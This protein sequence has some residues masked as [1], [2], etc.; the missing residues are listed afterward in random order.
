MKRLR[1]P[2]TYDRR[3]LAACALTLWIALSP[4]VWGFADS[5]SAVANHVAVV[6]AFGPLALL[7]VNLP[8]AAFVTLLG[9]LWL[10]VSPWLLGYA[11]DHAAWLNELVSGLL[12]IA[13]CASA[14]GVFAVVT[15]SRESFGALAR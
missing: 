15:R 6:F 1:L 11:T 13:L 10:T 12:L 9:G 3:L 8:P 2:G 4:W 14:G 7:M 5:H